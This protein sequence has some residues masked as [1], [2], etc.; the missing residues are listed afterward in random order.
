M[1]LY[2]SGVDMYKKY[3]A[4]YNQPDSQTFKA[5]LRTEQMKDLEA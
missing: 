4:K 5:S 2:K 1:P 3:V